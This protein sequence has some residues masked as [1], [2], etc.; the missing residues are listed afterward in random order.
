MLIKHALYQLSWVPSLTLGMSVVFKMLAIVLEFNYK[1][2]FRLTS[3][4]YPRI[5]ESQILYKVD[6]F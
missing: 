2:Y 4:K 5:H 1:M 6:N 3:T